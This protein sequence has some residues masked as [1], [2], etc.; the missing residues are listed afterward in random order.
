MLGSGLPTHELGEAIGV[1]QRAA[2]AG[3]GLQTLDKEIA[4]VGEEAL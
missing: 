1:A 4:A 3:V 2:I